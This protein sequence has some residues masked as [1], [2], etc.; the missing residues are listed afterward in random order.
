[1]ASYGGGLDSQ[2]YSTPWSTVPMCQSPVTGQE[3][4]L[5]RH[6]VLY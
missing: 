6:M 3:L 2:F 4:F 1:M 5:E